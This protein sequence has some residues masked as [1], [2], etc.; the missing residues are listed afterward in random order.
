MNALEDIR[1]ILRG[2]LAALGGFGGRMIARL[3]LI[4]TAGQL[5]GA[6]AFGVLGQ[7]AAITE[8][9]AAVATLGLRRSL[10]DFLSAH[11]S[12][13]DA[14]V[15]TIKEALISALMLAVLLSVLLGIAWPFLFTDLPMPLILYFSIPAIVFSEVAG[16][17]IRFKRIIRWEVIA[18]YIMEPWFF[19]IAALLFYYSGVVATG[20]I[21]AYSISHLAAAVGIAKGLS[22]TI[23]IKKILTTETKWRSLHKLP[24]KSLPVG[25]TDLGVMMFRRID[26]L[27]LS[28]AVSHEVAGLYYMAQQLVT[29]PHK[30]HQLF[31]PMMAPVIAKLHHEAETGA[32]A[33]KMEGLCRWVFTLQIAVT[34]PFMVFAAQLLGLF[35]DQFSAGAWVFIILLIAELFDGSFALI[36]TPLVFAKPK[37]PLKLILMALAIEIPAIAGLSHIWGMVGAAA[38]FLLAMASLTT[39]RLLMLN[40]H[41]DIKIISRAFIKPAALAIFVGIILQ[42]ATTQLPM[43]AGYV[44]GPAIFLA[45][46][47]FLGLIRFLAL[48]PGDKQI[49]QQLRSG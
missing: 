2:A 49:I 9:T 3:V 21:I 17:A 38:G 48:T 41:L 23:G 10:L 30:I 31:E 40:K 35:G 46:V 8:I 28:V 18:R 13:E 32:I 45:I 20:I 1:D 4:L 15:R 29:V 33:L 25:V 22:D 24:L 6:E 43:T 14:I 16:T 12:D 26:I 37:I 19:L 42:F 36:E 44:F 27:V 7:I 34:V 11:H 5:F 47:I 39:A